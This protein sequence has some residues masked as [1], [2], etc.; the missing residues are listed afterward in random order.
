MWFSSISLQTSMAVLDSAGRGSAASWAK[1]VE[2]A[3]ANVTA[4][5]VLPAREVAG[6]RIEPHPMTKERK[7]GTAAAESRFALTIST[8][9]PRIFTAKGPSGRA[10]ILPQIMQTFRSAGFPT[11]CQALAIRRPKDRIGTCQT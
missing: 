4:I 5:S 10:D 6:N 2:A 9:P 1:I 11:G 3:R 7:W 8:R